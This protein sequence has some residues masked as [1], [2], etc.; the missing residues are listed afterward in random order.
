M[1]DGNFDING[2]PYS[3]EIIEMQDYDGESYS[4]GDMDEHLPES[5][6]VFYSVQRE[7][8]DFETFYRWVGGPFGDLDDVISA[9]EAETDEYE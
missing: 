5:D 9:I 6:M 8:G 1:A 7:F 4:G 3:C 2:R